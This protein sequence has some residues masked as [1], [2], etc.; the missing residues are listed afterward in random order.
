LAFAAIAVPWILFWALGIGATA[1]A[2]S[3][4]NLWSAMWPVLI[5]LALGIGL[6]RWERFLPRVPEGDVV[7]YEERAARG[8]AAWGAPLERLE[9]MFRHWSVASLLLLAVALILCGALVGSGLVAR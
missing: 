5:G 9:R 3:A 1:D 8:V 6:S 7:V 4:D 2:L